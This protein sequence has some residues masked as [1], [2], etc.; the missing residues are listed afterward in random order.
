MLG[1]SMPQSASV[2]EPQPPAPSGGALRLSAASEYLGLGTASDWLLESD[3]PVARCDIR[4]PGAARPVWVWLK[5]DLD[6][7]L[8][9]RRVEPGEANPQEVYSKS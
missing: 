1:R 9:R 7:F 6:A 8:E 3:C 4:R 2:R 5:R